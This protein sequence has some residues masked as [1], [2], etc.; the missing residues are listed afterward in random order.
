MKK[1]DIEV[2]KEAQVLLST[3]HYCSEGFDLPRLD[4][5]FLASP[6]TDIEQSV[7]RVLRQHTDKQRPLILDF[8]DTFSV[9]D[10]QG[11]KRER[12]FKSLKCNI[13]TC[14]QL[15]LLKK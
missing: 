9:F 11:D 7:G 3:Y 13:Q 12:Y 15:T 10:S 5:L 1:E 2:S 6:R 8:V 4:T 14:E